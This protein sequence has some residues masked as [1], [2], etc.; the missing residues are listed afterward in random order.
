MEISADTVLVFFKEAESVTGSAPACA[1]H[2][3]RSSA[4]GHFVFLQ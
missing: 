4:G 3:A 2:A 1:Q